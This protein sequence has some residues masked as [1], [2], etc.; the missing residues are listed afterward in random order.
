M[1][2]KGHQHAF[3]AIM[4]Q[5]Q[6]LL[7]HLM[8]CPVALRHALSLPAASCSHSPP[9]TCHSWPWCWSWRGFLACVCYAWSNPEDM[10]WMQ[11][12]HEHTQSSHIFQTLNPPGA[13]LHS[14]G[15]ML[16]GAGG[17]WCQHPLGQMPE[18]HCVKDTGTRQKWTWLERNVHESRANLLFSNITS[19]IKLTT[20]PLVR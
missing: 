18:A 5:D 1:Q 20:F 6:L 12:A 4:I 15:C 2:P 11:L 16:T 3:L 17:S 13:R 14:R 10:V 7:L 8:T 9:G 19:V